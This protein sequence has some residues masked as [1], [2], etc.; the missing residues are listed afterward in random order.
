MADE[1]P[2]SVIAASLAGAPRRGAVAFIFVTILLDMFALGLILPI[3]PKLVESFVDNDTANA[4]R[5]FGLFGT[6]WAVM[7]FLFSPILGGLSDRF[8]RR[9]VVLLSNFGLAL[10]YV[11]MALAP[12]LT[13][14]FVG[15][16]ISGITSASVSTAFAYIADLTPPE[17]RAAVFGKIGVAFGAGF[18]LGPAVGGLLGGMDPRLPFWVAAGLSFANTLYGL[19]ILPESLPPD[20]RSPFHWRNANP[21]GALHLLRSDRVL[22]GLSVANFLAQL[23]HVVLPSTFVLY[24]TYRYGWDTTTVGL[25]LAIVGVC[26]MAV[27][28]AAIGPIVKRF[29]ERRALLLGLG[30]GALGFLIYGAAPTGPLFWF[31][32][33]VMALW[34]VAGAAL[35]AL[36][37]QRVAPDQQGQLQ[38]ATSSMQSVSQLVGPFLFTLTFAY[39]I[40]AQA[41]LKLPGAPFLLA[42]ALLVLA[43]VIAARTLAVARAH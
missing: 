26:S 33:P 35:Q 3:L 25:T 22:T 27:Q 16:V 13:W 24:A 23:A 37:T 34:G 42:S 30:F 43:L 41:P 39:F 28:G 4:A 5:I 17:Q 14:L 10:D 11:L 21:L 1:P 9:P 19:L 29:G 7:Q 31:G 40:G 38:G 12:S 2:V 32:I 8:G 6:V 15:R 36:T 20:R 18:I